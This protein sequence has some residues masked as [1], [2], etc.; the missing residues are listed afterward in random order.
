M[1]NVVNVKLAIGFILIYALIIYFGG[2]A[3]KKI[4]LPQET[5]E[6]NY[7]NII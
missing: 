5:L 1:E 4:N 2:V 3:I 7:E 6:N